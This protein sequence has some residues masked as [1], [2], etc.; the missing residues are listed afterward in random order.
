MQPS[1]EDDQLR[2]RGIMLASKRGHRF[3]FLISFPS[4]VTWMLR[5]FLSY[6]EM[7]CLSDNIQDYYFVSQGKTTIPNV[8]DGEELQLTD[9]R[10]TAERIA[11]DYSFTFLQWV[12]FFFWPKPSALSSLCIYW[13]TERRDFECLFDEDE[14]G[15]HTHFRKLILII[16]QSFQILRSLK[17]YSSRKY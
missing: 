5:S 16:W 12:V 7:C 1:F 15:K 14:L 10:A 3:L 2:S 11:R 8:D 6:T 4:I 9:V 13:L 17:A